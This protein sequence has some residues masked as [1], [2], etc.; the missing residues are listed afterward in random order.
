MHATAAASGPDAAVITLI[1]LAAV[2]VYWT[3][4]LI[5]LIRHASR[6]AARPR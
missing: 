5:A 1:W 6:T 3:P 2:A 4:A